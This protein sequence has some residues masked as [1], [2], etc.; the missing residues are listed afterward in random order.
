MKKRKEDLNSRRKTLGK[1]DIAYFQKVLL[2]WYAHHARS[3]PW[4]RR[5]ATTYR[6]IVSEIL[7]QKTPAER[8]AHYFADF[9]KCFPSWKALASA[10]SR[11]L[12]R[13]LWPFGLWRVRARLLKKLGTEATKMRGRFPRDPKELC[14]LPGVGPYAASAIL[15]F[16]YGEAEPLLD[17]NMA[18]LTWRFFVGPNVP[19]IS[20]LRLQSMAKEIVACSEPA[21]L[22]WA[23]Q[24][25]A[26]A[27]C[28][29]REPRHHICPLANRCRLFTIISDREV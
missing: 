1:R 14:K 2:R 11:R 6:K 22:N 15:L 24:D 21:E 10:D 20:N 18:R 26:A 23:I 27:V 5:S 16:R 12:Q 7:L 3:F 17:G 4:R 13:F 19:D 25:L 28:T 9:V 29:L 8:V